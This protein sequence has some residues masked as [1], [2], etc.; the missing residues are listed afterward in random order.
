MKHYP[1]VE[2]LKNKNKTKTKKY[3]STQVGRHPLLVVASSGGQKATEPVTLNIEKGATPAPTPSP[4]PTQ[5]QTSSNTPKDTTKSYQ[6]LRVIGTSAGGSAPSSPSSSSS[7]SSGS[8]TTASPKEASSEGSLSLTVIPIV[9]VVGVSPLL[10]AAFWYWRRLKKRKAR[11]ESK[12][13]SCP[14]VVYK[15]S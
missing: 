6:D 5:P 14:V 4:S 1:S 3:N 7:S 8:S 13:R 15:S 11:A 9:L 2:I 12:V 10:L